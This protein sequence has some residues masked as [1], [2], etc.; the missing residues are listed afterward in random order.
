MIW[1]GRV[2]LEP[3]LPSTVVVPQRTVSDPSNIFFYRC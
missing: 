1:I 3:L 2:Q